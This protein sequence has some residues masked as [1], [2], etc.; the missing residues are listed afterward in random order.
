M[1]AIPNIVSVARNCANYT[2]NFTVVAPRV[3]DGVTDGLI[4]AFAIIGLLYAL[5]RTF[6]VTRIKLDPQ[7]RHTH[8]GYGP[9]DITAEYERQ[10]ML[11][12]NTE[13]ATAV[14]TEQIVGRVAEIT[15]A[16]ATGAKSFLYAE[17][18]IMA[19]FI[20]VFAV[21][22]LLADGLTNGWKIGGF[23]A[24]SFVVGGVTSIISGLIGMR[25]AVAANGRTAIKAY[26][27][28]PEAFKTAFKAGTVMGFGLVSLG[29]IVLFILLL[30]FDQAFVG[31]C[32][33]YGCASYEWCILMTAGKRAH[34]RGHC[35]LWSWRI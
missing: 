5:L 12:I 19:I 23:S 10:P 25:I 6:E 16:I 17:Y 20:A 27:G 22:L 28:Y 7:G 24:L 18:K 3:G 34:V 2:N 33:V 26:E 13:D 8:R 29:L 14:P 21:I 35:G 31:N 15:D 32:E 11:P 1:E 9:S 30:I 4:V